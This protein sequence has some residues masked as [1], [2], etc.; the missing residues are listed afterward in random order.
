MPISTSFHSAQNKVKETLCFTTIIIW[1]YWFM[2]RIYIFYFTFPTL[3]WPLWKGFNGYLLGLRCTTGLVDALLLFL[4]D[5][6]YWLGMAALV[7]L[8][9]S[10]STEGKHFR[11]TSSLPAN[12]HRYL[13][14]HIQTKYSTISMEIIQLHSLTDLQTP[15]TGSLN[16]W[17]VLK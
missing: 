4:L 3:L 2:N 9:L 13:S 7:S 12:K 14:I 16:I 15:E 6:V 17:V 11:A 8:V 10:Q 1:A 5:S